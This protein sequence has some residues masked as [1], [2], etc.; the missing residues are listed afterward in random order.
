MKTELF[1][2]IKFYKK[3]GST[4]ALA[5]KLLADSTFQEN[6]VLCAREQ[7][8]GMGRMDRKWYSPI[9]GLYFTLGFPN[10]KFP[11]SMTL[12][13]GVVIHKV[14][15]STFPELAFSIKWAN[16]IFINQ[17]KV[18]GILTS[19]HDSGTVIGIGIDC[20]V[21]SMPDNL[22]QIATSLMLESGKRTSIKKLLKVILNT[23][24]NNFH[25]FEE[26]GLSYFV[27]Y[28]ETFHQLSN[29]KIALYSGTKQLT[30][31]VRGITDEGA[32]QLE[33]ESG[34]QTILS[35]DKIDILN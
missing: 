32:L 35:A 24:E 5:I 13:T 33:T 14:L 7:T 1:P 8:G 29:K 27:D 12:F 18:G 28:F 31:I 19:A 34:L 20:N 17:K 30:G 25:I 26:K 22:R 15:S 16:D 9:G 2:V 3:V 10:Q 11:A 4:N 23:F 21:Q 6:F